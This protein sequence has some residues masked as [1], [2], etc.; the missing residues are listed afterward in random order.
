MTERARAKTWASGL[1]LT[2]RKIELELELLNLKK[3]FY[4]RNQRLEWVRGV[5]ED[6]NCMFL[7][8]LVSNFQEHFLDKAKLKRRVFSSL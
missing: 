5:G 6:T 8:W 7:F 4:C 2:R 3:T 1:E